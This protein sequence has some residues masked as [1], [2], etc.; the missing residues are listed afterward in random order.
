MFLELYK[1]GI[2]LYGATLLNGRLDMVK[3]ILESVFTYDITCYQK[4]D[5]D[6][7]D[8]ENDSKIFSDCLVILTEVASVLGSDADEFIWSLCPSLENALK[9]GDIYE[10]EEVF[11]HF[12]DIFESSPSLIEKLCDR[13]VE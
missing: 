4:G 1:D 2:E 3:N 11:G 12:C 9:K 8:E 7:E 6:E 5:E 10:Y 13:M